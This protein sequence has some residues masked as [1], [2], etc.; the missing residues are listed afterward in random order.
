MFGHVQSICFIEF[1]VW[2]F[3]DSG[4]WKIQIDS[5]E[6]SKQKN[7]G[8]QKTTNG[9]T[10]LDKNS[11]F[12]Q[13]R[14]E[15]EFH[16][17]NSINSIWNTSDWIDSIDRILI[18]WIEFNPLTC[19][20]CFYLLCVSDMFLVFDTSVIRFSRNQRIFAA[21]SQTNHRSAKTFQ[22][23]SKKT[24]AKLP[25]ATIDW[26]SP[27]PTVNQDQVNQLFQIQSIQLIEL[28]SDW[29]HTILNQLWSIQSTAIR[30]DQFNQTIDWQIL[31]WI[32]L[33]RIWI[34]CNQFE[35]TNSIWNQFWLNWLNWNLN[36]S[37]ILIQFDL[38]NSINSIQ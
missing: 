22:S 29:I 30:I 3:G 17:I 23:M 19:A 36:W 38:I 32:E 25:Q 18:N 9:H 14:R 27:W 35:P 6:M 15:G 1:S 2:H 24:W 5:P 7:A 13:I 37:Q 20:T 21:V 8:M 4:F 33:I 10:K 26:N 11:N 28:H 31:S 16:L 34:N 12:K